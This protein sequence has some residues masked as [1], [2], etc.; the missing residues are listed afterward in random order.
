MLANRSEERAISMSQQVAEKVGILLYLVHRSRLEA[1]PTGQRLIIEKWTIKNMVKKT[2]GDFR[3]W[4][5][6][7]KWTNTIL[8]GKIIPL[9]SR[10][11]AR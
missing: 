6:I 9:P 7:E 8:G 2:F 10:G 4:E 3:D 1:V 11:E 5:A